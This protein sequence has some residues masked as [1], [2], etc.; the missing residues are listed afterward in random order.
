LCFIDN[1]RTQGF[2][3]RVYVEH[4]AR[5]EAPLGADDCPALGVK[6]DGG[7]VVVLDRLGANPQVLCFT[8]AAGCL[9]LGC[10][11]HE[12]ARAG[13]LA[14]LAASEGFLCLPLNALSERRRI[15]VKAKRRQLNPEISQRLGWVHSVNG[16]AIEKEAWAWLL[17]NVAHFKSIHDLPTWVQDWIVESESEFGTHP[18]FGGRCFVRTQDE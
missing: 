9:W 16:T 7:S 17:A 12:Q 1:A 18:A 3:L 13:W 5:G 4:Q 2:Q 14:P 15:S 8:K 10:N 6:P 11:Q